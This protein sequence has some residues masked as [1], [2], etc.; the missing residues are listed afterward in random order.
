MAP[1]A[2][3]FRSLH[4]RDFRL[5]W[6]GMIAALTGFWV[7][8]V[9]QGWLVYQ[10]TDSA[11]MLG[12]VGFAGS[13]PILF[14]SL[15]GGVLADR[16]DRR[17]LLIVTRSF[18]TLLATAL[19]ALT[20]AGLIQVWQIAAIAFMSGVMMSFDMP[21]RQAL[22]PNLVAREDLA[23]AVALFSVAFNGTRVVGPAV[24]GALVGAIGVAGC[25][26]LTA[27]SHLCMVGTLLAMRAGKGRPAP[28]G[29]TIW[30]DLWEGLGYIGRDAHVLALLGLVALLTFFGMPYVVFL[31]VF[32]RDILGVGAGGLGLMMAATGLGAVASLLSLAAMG[33]YRGKG[34]VMLGG[35][36]AFGCFLALFAASRWFGA[37]LLLLAAVGA[38]IS[39]CMATANTLLQ[40]MVPDQLRGRVMSVYMLTWGLMPLGQLQM[41]LAAEALSTPWAVGLGGVLCIASGLAA[42]RWVPGLRKL[43]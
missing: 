28:T 13:I 12:L 14:L 15:F 6:L 35:V 34:W 10:L 16:F 38:A 33:N 36:M 30:E 40:G 41:G 29:G 1:I 3:V 24:A 43:E 19:A 26:Y 5:L 22:V 21:S 31:P 25:F 9:A 39:A 20:G 42:G 18:Y 23:N 32:A 8:A 27:L 7:Q 17:R 37:S 11:F 4:Y 2:R